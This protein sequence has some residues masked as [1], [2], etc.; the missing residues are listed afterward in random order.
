MDEM[1]SI[2]TIYS[3]LLLDGLRK[4]AVELKFENRMVTL[5]CVRKVSRRGSPKTQPQWCA[6][7]L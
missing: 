2:E 1:D 4:A 3:V 6:R 5:F 7:V